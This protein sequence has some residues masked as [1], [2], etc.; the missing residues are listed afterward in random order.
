ML[1]RKQVFNK[2][3]LLNIIIHLLF[4]KQNASTSSVGKASY[5]EINDMGSLLQAVYAVVGNEH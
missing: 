5:S 3:S 2:C 1:G 4:I